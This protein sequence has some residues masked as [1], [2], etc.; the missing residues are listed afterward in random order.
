MPTLE[1]CEERLKDEEWN[2]IIF[3]DVSRFC[4]G[5][6]NSRQRVQC[7]HGERRQLRFQRERHVER[8]VGI[9]VWGVIVYGSRSCLLFIRRSMTAQRYVQEVLQPVVVPY[10]RQGADTLFQQDNAKHHVARV[11]LRCLEDP[12]VPILPWPPRSSDLF[13]TEHGW[14]MIGRRLSRVGAS[15]IN[16]SATAARNF[17]CI[18]SHPSR[19]NRSPHK[20]YAPASEGVY[21]CTRGSD[22]LLTFFL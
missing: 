14:D 13:P 11:S 8:T 1:W 18:G 22:A 2:N 21:K 20:K 15:S 17:N 19:G 5:M 3:S 16:P 4:L 12:H 7:L 6:N 10:I 9:M